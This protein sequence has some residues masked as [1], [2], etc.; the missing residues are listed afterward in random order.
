V[1]DRLE[2]RSVRPSEVD[3]VADLLARRGEPADAVDVRLVIDDP[4]EGPSSVLVAV[5]G[6]RVVSTLTLLRESVRV[7]TVVLPA[8]QIELV[9][10][11]PDHEGRGLVRSLVDVAHSI[12]RAGG[13]VVQVMIGIPFFY[14]QFGYVYSMP[15]ADTRRLLESPSVI[16]H[17][18]DIVVREATS[19]DIDA[20]ATL[21]DREQAEASVAMPH[22]S[23]CWRWLVARDGSAQWVAE[24]GGV[25]IATARATPPDDALYLG[26]IAGDADGVRAILQ[27]ART[28]A[29]DGVPVEVMDRGS[30]LHEV[31]D[32]MLAPIDEADRSW[33]YARVEQPSALFEALRPELGRRWAAAGGDEREL[34]VSSYRSHLRFRLDPIAG[35]G[36]VSAGG[37]LQAP[38]SAGGSGVPLDVIAPLV[39]GPF[40]AL[41]L[42][43]R[44][45]DVLLGH[46]REAMA[47]L[48]PPQRADVLTFYLPV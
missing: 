15:I 31:L 45:P 46:Q 23:A 29:P 37:P 16:E 2:I 22:T 36:P 10:T 12:S 33:Y 1:T 34:L 4:D 48:F 44:Q 40:G 8:A 28:V 41:E 42:E 18:R 9:A 17:E 7:G 32:P 35:M 6:D 47:V 30:A 19:A 25:V 3:Q 27:H 14:R 13:D 24:R 39:F 5:D 21:Q 43:R 26:E 11:E 20:M 38:V